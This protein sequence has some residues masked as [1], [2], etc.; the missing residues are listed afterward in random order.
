M[1]AP[2]VSGAARGVATINV[3]KY[4]LK[5]KERAPGVHFL[6][7]REP[8]EF[9]AGHMPGAV[10]YPLS[11]LALHLEELARYKRIYVS[12]QAGRRS[13][14]AARTLDYLG[15]PD[16]VNVSGGFKAWENAGLPVE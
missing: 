8:D 6:D 13:G 4:A 9:R 2:A 14:P 7:V 1:P 10:N 5:M 3:E 11:E 12:C 16:V 15:F